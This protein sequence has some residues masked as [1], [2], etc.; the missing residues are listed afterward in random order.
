MERHNIITRGIDF[1]RTNPQLLYT[2][3]LA[4]IIPLAFILTSEQFLKVAKNQND[5]AER[6]RIG[7]LHDAFAS[8][9]PHMLEPVRLEQYIQ[10]IAAQNQTLS[11]FFVLLEYDTGTTTRLEVFASQ[12]K[13][14]VSL[15]AY[16][17]DPITEML[18]RFAASDSTQ[19]YSAEFV[20]HTAR[21]WK[22]VRAIQKP[23]PEIFRAY[24]VTDVS[25]SETDVA[26]GRNIRNAYIVL[27]IVVAMVM[28]LL[29]R[30]ARIVDYAT[31]Y[32]KLSEVDKM[33]DDFVSMAA[34]E[35]RSP[36]TVIRGY[37]D[38]MKQN[39]QLSARSI[40]M[41][42]SIDNAAQELN[43]LV[44]DILDVA[45]LQ[46]GRMSFHF[47][48]I[49][50]TDIAGDVYRAFAVP[51][52]QKGL[53]F[54]YTPTKDER[55]IFVDKTRLRQILVNL[56]GNAIKYTPQGSVHVVVKTTS[57]NTG[58]EIRVSDTGLG[59][60][61]EAQ[62]RLFS[63]FY[64]VKTKDTEKIAGTGLGL[65]ITAELVR[66]MRGAISVESIEGKGTDFI[67]RFPF[68]QT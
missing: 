49:L 12:Q 18:M 48:S 56:V 34:H 44:G 43:T 26:L 31:L 14:E 57:D 5:A 67:V 62:T 47:A 37:A 58:V 1:V 55:R 51:A 24:V 54:V 25:M 4:I 59:I 15:G 11:G 53:E 52:K 22:T 6:S 68:Q 19:S 21:Q 35:L 36:L 9:L 42:K 17:P 64:R 45:K 50:P 20:K 63:K 66:Q 27:C 3:F 8:F 13:D 23:S 2:I 61:A 30:Q 46:E 39:E 16:T 32:R 29:G 38:M 33:K 28:V 65:W 41:L 40:D 60:S 10:S 7:L